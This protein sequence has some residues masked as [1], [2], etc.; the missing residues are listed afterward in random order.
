MQ[1]V[2][3]VER[4]FLDTSLSHYYFANTVEFD[5]KI[6]EGGHISKAWTG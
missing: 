2:K 1:A 3:K 4:N 6:G 5:S